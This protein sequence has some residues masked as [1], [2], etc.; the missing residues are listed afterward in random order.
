[1]P[2][3]RRP[4]RGEPG[5]VHPGGDLRRV[6]VP[7]RERDRGD[8]DQPGGTR[9]DP[10]QQ[11]TFVPADQPVG[12]AAARLALVHRTGVVGQHGGSPPGHRDREVAQPRHRR[13]GVDQLGSGAAQ[14]AAQLERPERA[15]RGVGEPQPGGQPH[16]PHAVL[17]PHGA[18]QAALAAGQH[19]G[20]Q[21]GGVGQGAGDPGRVVLHPADLRRVVGRHDGHGPAVHHAS[22]SWGWAG[23]PA[24]TGSAGGSSAR[25]RSTKSSA[26]AA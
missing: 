10:G 16:H 9:E 24:D 17:D 15:E 26:R 20:A 18:A 2:W 19:H 3:S 5:G 11:Q 25:S 13:V 1:M 6:R 14:P 7:G 8:R 21:V 4:A 22:A 12:H 23:D